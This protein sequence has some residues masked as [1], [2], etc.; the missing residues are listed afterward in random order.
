ME[1]SKTEKKEEREKTKKQETKQTNGYGERF[2]QLR[3][4]AAPPE[5]LG[6]NP[7]TH[8]AAQNYF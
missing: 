7:S 8:M 6:S 4:L 1:H 5:D 2:H 3:A